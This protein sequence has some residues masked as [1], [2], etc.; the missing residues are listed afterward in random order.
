MLELFISSSLLILIFILSTVPLAIYKF[1]PNGL[2][3]LEKR[4]PKPLKDWLTRREK[5][6]LKEYITTYV[7]TI[8]FLL[9]FWYAS[10]N[11]LYEVH[12]GIIKPP[13][14][15]QIFN[16]ILVLNLGLGTVYTLLFFGKHFNAKILQSSKSN[17]KKY[18]PFVVRFLIGWG[19]QISSIGNLA[20]FASIMLMIFLF[21]Q[22]PILANYGAIILPITYIG[23][24]VAASCSI[25]GVLLTLRISES[26]VLVWILSYL[27]EIRKDPKNLEHSFMLSKTLEY[28][29]SF[30]QQDIHIADQIDLTKYFELLYITLIWGD[31]SERKAA[32]NEIQNLI[33]TVKRDEPRKFIETLCELD[34]N[35]DLASLLKIKSSAKITIIKTKQKLLDNVSK[36][37]KMLSAILTI[38]N[39]S[40]ILWN[41]LQ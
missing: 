30:I 12:S 40:I 25:V 1:H 6:L 33:A 3:A 9:S 41:Y 24:F 2:A 22:S 20:Y 7:F 16:I 19:G 10:I 39:V 5:G 15:L 35:S 37:I 29:Q 17:R 34:K 32:V 31:T 13:I 21:P 26:K 28:S 11:W 8:T 18:L 36:P 14:E 4:T 27:K 38:V 23:I